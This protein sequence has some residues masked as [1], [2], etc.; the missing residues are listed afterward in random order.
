M[1][2]AY[3]DPPYPGQAKRHYG[4]DKEVNHRVL[5]ATLMAD[6]PDGWALST[7][8]PGLEHII[9]CL[10]A[11]GLRRGDKD[12]RVM[13]WVKP[14]CSFKPGV[15]PAFAWEPVIVHGGRK[16]TRQQP[17]T[18]DW[19]SANITLKKGLTGV[20]P[21]GFCFWLFDTLNIEEG[22]E[23]CD[24]FPG[25]GAVTAALAKWLVRE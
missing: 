24:V 6:Y 5:I 16:R 3:A 14:F 20:K 13:P 18:R 4:Y 9:E 21:E 8:E 12:Y 1:K 7:S 19:I 11:N 17:T 23:F 10:N 22:D 2:F 25:S 15:N